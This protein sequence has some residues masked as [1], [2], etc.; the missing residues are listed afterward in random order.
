MFQGPFFCESM[1]KPDTP[2]CHSSTPTHFPT[3]HANAFHTA[4]S[5]LVYKSWKNIK[6]YLKNHW[7]NTRLVSTHLNAIS[8]WI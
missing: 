2:Y 6:S 1:D 4:Y 7:T 8:Y 5:Y 3:F